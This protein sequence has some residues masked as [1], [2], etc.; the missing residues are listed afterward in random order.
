MLLLLSALAATGSAS[1]PPSCSFTLDPPSLIRYGS[2]VLS[3]PLAA[4]ASLSDCEA[5]CCASAS[6]EAFSFNSPQPSH[7][8]VGGSCC[9]AG[10]ICCMLKNG[11]GTLVNNTYGPAVRTGF[12]AAAPGPTPP[13]PPSSFILNVSFG[14]PSSWGT[15]NGD[16]WPTAWAADGRL[17]GWD[18]DA[19]GSP[20]SLWSLVGDAFAGNLSAEPVGSLQAINYTELCA[21]LG[22]TGSYPYIN[23]KPGGMLALPATAAAPQGTLITGISCMNYGDDIGFN[24]Q[25]NLA[26]FLSSSTDGGAS[27]QNRTAV[28]AFSGR[29]SAPVFVSCGQANAPCSAKDAGLLYVFFPGADSNE[30]FW[31]NNDAMFLARVLEEQVLNASAYQFFAGLDGSSQPQWTADSSQA[32]AP[33]SYGRM[34]GENTVFYNPFIGRYLV[35]NFGFIDRAGS[36]RP[37]HT[38]PFMSPHRTQLVLLEAPEPWGPWSI[39]FRSDETGELPLQSPGLYT[40]SFPSALMQPVQAGA[41]SASMIMFFSCLGGPES[42]KY[43]LNYAEVT[44]QLAQQ[45]GGEAQ[46]AQGKGQ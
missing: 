9:E 11:P 2:D 15:S 38:E 12:S 5:L 16:T 29:F 24:R 25:H 21:P 22:R 41:D 4:S 17:L 30:A 37:W 35:A 23:V 20:M 39:F 14:A 36:P 8:C 28:G 40:P 6:C 1:S 3:S 44:L 27:W 45:Q 34:L 43:T 26:G 13:F 10:S 42:C 7:T 46:A 33:I 32:Q 31:D 18:C 19:H